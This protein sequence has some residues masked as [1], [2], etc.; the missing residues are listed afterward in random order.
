M[1]IPQ[2]VFDLLKDR[3]YKQH[4]PSFPPKTGKKKCYQKK[5]AGIKHYIGVE[6]NFFEHN[7][8]SYNAYSVMIYFET[9]EDR[10]KPVNLS[11]YSL[12]ADDLIQDL[13]LLERRLVNAV[14]VLGGNPESYD[15]DD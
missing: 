14:G 7:G 12:S 5:L 11:F 2:R 1:I 9:K 10:S 4:P 13:A 15:N 8:T 3:G 6:W